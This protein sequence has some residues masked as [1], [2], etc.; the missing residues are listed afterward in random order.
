MT[1]F[2]GGKTMFDSHIHT[3]YSTDSKLKIEDV[4]S[5]AQ[6]MGIGATITEH[7]DINFPKPN[8]FI[9]NVEDYFKEYDK[10]RN[11]KLMLGIEMGMMPSAL[12]KCKSLA[13]NY[14]FDYII[15]S[16]H[17]VHGMDLFQRE[18]YTSRTKEVVYSQYLDSILSSIRDYDF[19]D[20]LAHIDYISR[21]AQFSDKEL[22]Y[23]VFKEK[24]DGILKELAYREKALEINTKRFHE[25]S[26][27]ENMKNIY[28]RFYELGGKLVVIGSDAHT[29]EFVGKNLKLAKELADFSKLNVVYFKSRIPEYDR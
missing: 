24:I 17:L 18:F 11:P 10:F 16:V 26:A 12:E 5:K 2:I 3:K 14:P 4:I 1:L 25:K 28:K 7:M 23:E 29:E 13:E 9:F 15:G 19:I 22:Y 21:Y 20:C 8:E 6:S 27:V